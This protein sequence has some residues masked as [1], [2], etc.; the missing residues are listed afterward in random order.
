MD[1]LLRASDCESVMMKKS[2]C[3]GNP[4]HHE[5]GQEYHHDG[6]DA[7]FYICV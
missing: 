1:T 3:G 4:S 6:D 5:V 7:S 2:V